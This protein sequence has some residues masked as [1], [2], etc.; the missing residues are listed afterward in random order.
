[1]IIIN[2]NDNGLQ[3]VRDAPAKLGTAV[4]LWA[5]YA[6][7]GRRWSPPTPLCTL[8]TSILSSL[9]H[10][11]LRPSR[12]IVRQPSRLELTCWKCAE[13][14][15]YSHLQTL[16]KD[17]FIRADYAF[18]ALETIF[19]FNVLHKCTVYFLILILIIIY[20][21]AEVSWAETPSAV[22]RGRK[23]DFF[24]FIYLSVTLKNGKICEYQ[25]AKKALCIETGLYAVL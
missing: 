13:I 5:L 14:D 25:F 6:S 3:T 1:M 4:P 7:G 12:V 18:S 10:F 9:Q 2:E 21:H 8:R 17:V 16:S 11:K 20:H 24:F 19:S 23:F 22:R 15:I